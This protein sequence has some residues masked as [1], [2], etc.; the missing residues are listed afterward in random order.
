MNLV[1]VEMPW[2]TRRVK[3]RMSDEDYRALQA[4]LLENPEKG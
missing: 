1:F 3:S 2:F 4:E